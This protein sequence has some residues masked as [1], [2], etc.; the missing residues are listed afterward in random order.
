MCH[1]VFSGKVASYHRKVS[2][3]PLVVTPNAVSGFG[4]IWSQPPPRSVSV[5]PTLLHP[6][7]HSSVSF[8]T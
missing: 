6:P 3:C 7:S 2:D 8:Q 5:P 4:P 1:K